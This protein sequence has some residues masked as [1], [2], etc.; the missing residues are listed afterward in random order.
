MATAKLGLELSLGPD[1]W[2]LTRAQINANF[3]GIDD[4]FGIVIC[5]SATRP[6]SPFAGQMIYETDTQFTYVRNVANTLWTM[7]ANIPS[8]ASTAA[9]SSPFT[10]QVVFVT[11]GNTFYRYTGASWVVYSLFSHSSNNTVSTG[12]Q[13]SSTSYTALTTAGP[14]VTIDSKGTQALVCIRATGF[15][16]TATARG[17]AIS[18]AISGATTLASSDSNGALAT[19]NQDGYGFTM[20]SVQLVTI[21]AGSNTYTMQYKTSALT[22]QFQARRMF[23][24][25]P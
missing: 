9:I 16:T 3:Q 21:T 22:S 1:L 18:F 7:T 19:C 25:A 6:S 4:K 14:A 11:T 2:S 15:G 8:V 24:F 12:E 5:T 17:I 23:V 13:T 10:G 20:M